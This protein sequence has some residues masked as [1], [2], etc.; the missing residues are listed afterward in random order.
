MTGRLISDNVII[1]F[2]C[3]HALNN[4]WSGKEGVVAMKTDM[5]KAYQR[6][7]LVYLK[8]VMERMGFGSIWIHLIMGS[9]E[10]VNFYVLLN[11]FP[12]QY[13]RP[14]RGLRQGDPLS[15]YHFLLCA[16]GSCTFPNR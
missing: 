6:V 12:R 4:K 9:V 2:E 8:K 5:S 15:P 16:E 1:G 3:L 14:K 11:G 13:F 10:S 7:E